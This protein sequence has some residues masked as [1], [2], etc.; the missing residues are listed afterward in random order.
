MPYYLNQAQIKMQSGKLASLTTKHPSRLTSFSIEW[1]NPRPASAVYDDFICISSQTYD[2]LDKFE[3]DILPFL[4]GQYE[5]TKTAW[6][7]NVMAA[8]T[9]RGQ[10]MLPTRVPKFEWRRDGSVAVTFAYIVRCPGPE[11]A[12]DRRVLRAIGYE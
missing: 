12:S 10:K 9:F 5:R 3:E 8:V 2:S 1:T 4:R 11:S 7:D 6:P